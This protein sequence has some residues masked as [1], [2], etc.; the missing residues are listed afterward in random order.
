MEPNDPNNN[1]KAHVADQAVGP[2]S[3]VAPNATPAPATKESVPADRA[4][5]I[6]TK[7]ENN[8]PNGM[9]LTVEELYDKDKHDLSTMEPGDVF[10]LLQ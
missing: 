8:V 10:Q 1:E 3:P 4:D 7:P 9:S 5:E 6:N 2:N